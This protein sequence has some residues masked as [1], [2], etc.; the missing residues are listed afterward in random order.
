MSNLQNALK[1]RTTITNSIARLVRR[2]ES[3]AAEAMTFD[4]TGELARELTEH[5][6]EFKQ[7]HYQI[8][9]LIDGGDTATLEKEQT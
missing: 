3:Q 8:I 5:D 2:L 7:Q 4:L 9:D 6:R 1:R